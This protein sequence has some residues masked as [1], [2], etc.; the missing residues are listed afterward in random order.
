MKYYNDTQRKN[1]EDQYINVYVD[2]SSM[3]YN[4]NILHVGDKNLQ[5]LHWLLLHTLI[6]DSTSGAGILATFVLFRIKVRTLQTKGL[7]T[8]Q[9]ETP[10]PSGH[11]NAQ[12]KTSRMSSDS[13]YLWFLAPKLPADDPLSL[14]RLGFPTGGGRTLGQ[15]F[16]RVLPAQFNSAPWTIMVTH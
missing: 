15:G 10:H 4:L 2:V 3:N 14:I 7:R 1:K 12:K 16:I 11:Q 5:T 9:S 13:G 6:Q 8:K